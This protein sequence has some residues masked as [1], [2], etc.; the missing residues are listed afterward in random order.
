[1]PPAYIAILLDTTIQQQPGHDAGIAAMSISLVAD[2]AGL[3]T[4][5]LGAIDRKQLRGLLHVPDTTEIVLLVAVGY[6]KTKPIID[7]V[8]ASNIR[9]W[10]DDAGQ[11][12]VPKRILAEVLSWNTY[13][14][15]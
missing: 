4:C 6:A 9:Y 10:L 13:Q 11:L 2:E 1:M 8:E 12:H 3:G 15:R 7:H 5:I 14:P